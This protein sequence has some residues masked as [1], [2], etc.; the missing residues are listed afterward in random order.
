MN[1]TRFGVGCTIALLAVIGPRRASALEVDVTTLR[2]TVAVVTAN[3]ALR[4]ALPDKFRR[5]VDDGGVVHLRVQAE[6]WERRPVWDRLV[7][8]TVVRVFRVSRSP[9]GRDI[10]ISDPD[11]AVTLHPTLPNPLELSIRV[12]RFTVICG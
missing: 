11:G 1:R 9:A 5:L 8:P 12:G 3:V 6:V 2:A 4:D 7:Y 10:A